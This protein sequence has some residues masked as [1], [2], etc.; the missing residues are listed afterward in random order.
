M[1]YTLSGSERVFYSIREIE[2]NTLTEAKEKYEEMI[3]CEAVQAEDSEDFTIEEH[4][5]IIN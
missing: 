2:A 3:A 1:K 5:N 4:K